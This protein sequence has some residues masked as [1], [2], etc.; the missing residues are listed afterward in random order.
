LNSLR[1]KSFV[2]T[3]VS[4]GLWLNNIRDADK[5]LRLFF[6]ACAAET[7]YALHEKSADAIATRLED[8][9]AAI[10]R[11]PVAVPLVTASSSTVTSASADYG[12]I[13]YG[14]VR[15][16]LFNFLLK[17]YAFPVNATA[18]ASALVALESRNGRPMWNLVKGGQPAFACQCGESPIFKPASGS[19][20]TL[21][22]ACSDGDVIQDS[23]EQ[24]QAH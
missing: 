17:P 19:E 9:Y 16:V 14:V 7:L 3:K 24:L 6:G 2:L 12:L 22:V 21:A 8:L 11:A 5:G 1:L 15:D 20:L 18:L 13:D 23:M 4:K 10:K